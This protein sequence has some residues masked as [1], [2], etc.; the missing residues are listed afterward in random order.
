MPVRAEE[1]RTGVQTWVREM[2]QQERAFL[3]TLG[4]SR[5]HEVSKGWE[6]TTEGSLAQFVYPHQSGM[7]FGCRDLSS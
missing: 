1:V 7:L 5:K 6:E 3:L 4:M 2:G